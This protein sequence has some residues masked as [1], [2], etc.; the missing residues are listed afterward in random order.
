MKK[1]K[2]AIQKGLNEIFE[3]LKNEGM[4]WYHMKIMMVMQI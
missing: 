4:M 1:Y 2:V 3:L